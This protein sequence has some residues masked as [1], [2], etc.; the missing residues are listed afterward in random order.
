VQAV[1]GHDK[2]EVKTLTKVTK[3]QFCGKTFTRA[4]WATRH[5]CAKKKKFEASLD[6]TLQHAYRMYTYWMQ[7][8][9]LHRKGKD[10][11]F[12]K[13]M[14]SPL[15]N[16]FGKL[17][18]FCTANQIRSPYSY[19]DWLVD[20]QKTEPNWYDSSPVVLEDYYRY[21]NDYE[22]PLFQATRTVAYIE[23]WLLEDETRT[24]EQFFDRLS[25]GSILT[26]VRKGAIL[27]W[28]LFTYEPITSRWLDRSA[29][30][31]DVFFRIDSI[32]NCG[33]WADK[34][35]QTPEVAA[36]VTEIMNQIWQ[37]RT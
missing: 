34:I 35:N 8:Q 25:P 21:T 12:E 24:P 17:V 16:A 32:V 2:A 10:P 18:A 19:V 1:R 22:D 29:Y 9:K 28:P 23:R 36:Q 27:P 3:C 15:R 11:D 7:K 4:S 13:F 5:T 31:A 33:Y 6:V 14:K 30:N 26:L 37:Y 20:T